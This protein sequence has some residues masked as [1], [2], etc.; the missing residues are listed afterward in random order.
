[1]KRTMAFANRTLKEIVR[2]PLTLGFGLGF[3]VILLSLLS[4]IQANIPVEMFEITHLTPG[5]TV[6]GLSF[7]TLFSAQLISKDRESSFLTRLYTTPMTA[8]SFIL[9]YMLPILPICLGQ[10][11]ICYALAMALGLSFNLNVIWAILMLLVPSL[12]Y[13]SLGLL[14]G[15]AMSS[16]QVGGICG[17]LLTNVSAWLSGIW[18]DIDL[19][20]GVFETIANALP[21]IHAVELERAMV[22]GD[23]AKAMSH[24]W[25]VLLYALAFL[26][27]AIWVFLRQM[28][29]Q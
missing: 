25:W 12:F 28:K 3:P 17:A 10:A 21:F 15:S 14:C 23:M 22:V 27:I 24:I 2:D 19:L 4:L 6:F 9:G 13:V 16:K 18:F 1:M 20:G 7:M 8:P 26:G 29:K 11:I 5:V